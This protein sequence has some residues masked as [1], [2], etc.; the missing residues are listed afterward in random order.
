MNTKAKNVPLL[1]D[2]IKVENNVL[3]VKKK[4]DLQSKK[5]KR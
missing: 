4:R 5:E 1:F 3:K 2:V